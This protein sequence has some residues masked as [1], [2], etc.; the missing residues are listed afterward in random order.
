MTLWARLLAFLTNPKA[1]PRL[2]VDAKEP[3][4][5]AAAAARG[6]RVAFADWVGLWTVSPD[7]SV[8]FAER[9]DL[10]DQ[11]EVRDAR[12]INMARFQAAARLQDLQ[13]LRPQRHDGD[14]DCPHCAGTGKVRLPTGSV[15]PIWCMCGGV[16]WLPQGYVDPS[17]DPAV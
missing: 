14:Y 15:G 4:W 11:V 13:R 6:Q 16:G 7:G 10:A 3:E 1:P 9:V 8:Y 2:A 17:R 12:A 5:I